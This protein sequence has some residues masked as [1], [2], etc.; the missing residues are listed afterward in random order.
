MPQRLQ[1]ATK[2]VVK[3]YCVTD[4]ELVDSNWRVYFAL[5]GGVAQW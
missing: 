3:L 4:R 5:V 2:S 1:H